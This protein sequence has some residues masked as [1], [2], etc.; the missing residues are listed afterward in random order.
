MRYVRIYIHCKQISPSGF[1]VNASQAWE[2]EFQKYG[3][4]DTTLTMNLF[5]SG[6]GHATQVGGEREYD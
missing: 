3:W 6:V 1:A 2:N 5:N 4:S